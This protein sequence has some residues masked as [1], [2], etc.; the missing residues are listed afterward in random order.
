MRSLNAVSLAE[1]FSARV[2]AG[3]IYAYV[4]KPNKGLYGIEINTDYVWFTASD[5]TAN[6]FRF[7]CGIL[8]EQSGLLCVNLLYFSNAPREFSTEQ[9][10]RG[11]F[12]LSSQSLRTS[13]YMWRRIRFQSG[14]NHLNYSLHPGSMTKNKELTLAVC[15]ISIVT[16]KTI[17]MYLKRPRNE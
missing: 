13:S 4:C 12:S 9:D 1:N 5:L 7:S 11:A 17:D 6:V 8:R 10:V 15:G 3:C 2:V 16:V 14:K